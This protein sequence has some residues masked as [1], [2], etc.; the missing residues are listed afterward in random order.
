MKIKR[1]V[2]KDMRTALLEVKNELGADAVIMSNT[3]TADGIEIVAAVDEETDAKVPPRKVESTPSVN[4]PTS[5]APQYSGA[6]FMTSN[7]RQTPSFENQVESR[8]NSHF[9]QEQ[10]LNDNQVADS[11]KSLLQ[12]QHEKLHKGL[13]NPS[14][15]PSP[16]PS[17][18]QQAQQAEHLAQF[19][20]KQIVNSAPNEPS[21]SVENTE[22]Q[23]MKQEMAEIRKLMEHQ[24][25][26]LMWQEMARR[27]PVRA[28][29]VDR[30]NKM[31]VSNDVSDQV[32]S[33]IPEELSQAEAWDNAL[34]LLSGQINVTNN[35]ILRRGGFVALLGPT[36]VGKTTTIAKLAA[37]FAQLHGS[38]QVAMVTTD[39]F[40]IGAHEQLQTYAKILGCP[41]KVVQ[42]QA[43]LSETLHQLRNKKL[44]LIDT[45]GVGQRD[46]R[47]A[48]HL[49]TLMNANQIKIRS[50]LVLQSTAQRR[51]MQDAIERFKQIP[52]TGC[53]FTKV[54][55]CTSLGEIISVAI[56][57]ALPV[58]YL[59]EGQRVPEDIR[60]AESAYLVEKAAQLMSERNISQSN[61]FTDDSLQPIYK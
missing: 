13:Q 55:E 24:V 12:R 56:Q 28:Y 35:D 4:N 19:A 34:E 22:L 54:D 16:A 8:I 50:Y 61:W 6:N 17:S 25:S 7:I 10:D 37:H 39:T 60:V 32:A 40:R 31:G 38:D 47:L 59:S 45:A 26:G 43:E 1:F 2:A 20:K 11:L 57:N 18:M 15:S 21:S 27:E 42:S 52:I 53:I 30:L 23:A 36:G 51:V 41:C 3:K 29:L 44:V 49:E 5:S 48:E 9:A 33:F 46:M 14:P 58:A